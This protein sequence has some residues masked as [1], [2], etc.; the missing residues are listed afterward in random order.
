M[1][2][3]EQIEILAFGLTFTVAFGTSKGLGQLSLALPSDVLRS[4]LASEYAFTIL[5]NP[6]WM[7]TKSS[8]LLFYLYI[9]KGAHRLWRIASYVTLA[10]VNVGGIVVTLLSALR[11]SPVRR[12]YEPG[13]QR[14]TCI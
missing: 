5:Y 13:A 12:A 11:C 10:V 8:I 6:A 3:T 14:L 9:A 4:L 1:T 2:D 7:A